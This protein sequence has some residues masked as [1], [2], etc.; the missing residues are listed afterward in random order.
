VALLLGHPRA[1]ALRTRLIKSDEVL[2]SAF[3]AA[4]LLAALHHEQVPLSEGNR[5]LDG[6]SLVFSGRSLQRECEAVLEHGYLR[7]ADLWHVASALAVAGDSGAREITFYT[8]D[9]RQRGLARKVGFRV[10]PA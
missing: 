4:E 3:A 1:E 9:E 10:W 8:L 7:G 5:M 2:S 6:I